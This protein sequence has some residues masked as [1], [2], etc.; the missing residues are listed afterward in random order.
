MAQWP[1]AGSVLEIGS[2]C[3][4]STIFIALGCK[5]NPTTF[6]AVDPHKPI[7]KGGKEQY[8]PDFQPYEGDSLTEIQKTIT[9]CGL[10][11]HV[12]LVVASS[13][14]ASQQL[15][16]LSLK[17]LFID[18]SHDYADVMMDY[19]L[20][21]GMIVVGGRLVF[22]DSNFEGVKDL[23]QNQLDRNRYVYEGTVG[24]GG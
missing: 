22:H 1:I 8:A 20:W 3:G 9:N 23:L 21:H 13:E 4:K 14:E 15:K 5:H 24:D 19:S 2:F 17:L 12:N 6:Y 18:G 16:A 11:D 10:N 7:S